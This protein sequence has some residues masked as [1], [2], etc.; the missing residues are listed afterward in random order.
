[1]K[2]WSKI[3][4][5]CVLALVMVLSLAACGTSSEPAPEAT[6]EVALD[7]EL[8]INIMSLNGP[9]GFG[10]AKMISDTAA[11]EAAL[12]YQFSV[13]ADPSN[14]T[15]ALVN[16]TCDIAALPTNAAST[17]YNKTEGAVQLLALNTRG[18]LYLVTDGSMEIT[19]FEDLKGQTIYVPAQNPTFI[20][21]FL[22]EKNGLKVGED[23]II[24]NT[25]AQS[26]DLRTALVS[27]EITMAVLPEPMV[28][29]A[30][31]ANDKLSVAMDLTEEWDKVFEPGS[32]VQ[33]CLV[34]R[35]E[36]A[37]A[38]PAE[39]AAF[40]SDYEASVAYIQSGDENV[41][42]VIEQSGVFAKGAVAA[43]AIP[44]CSL[45]YIVG[46]DMIAPMNTYLEIMFNA[47]PKSVG[48]ALPGEDFYYVAK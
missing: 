39:L 42:S 7:A 2:N 1:M 37:E 9:T 33:G 48:G 24:D 22:C 40:L 14:V 13:E 30:K 28:T 41:A 38:H 23:V 21:S 15:G 27:G 25:Y 17:L 11:G 44:N 16:G 19:S 32:L 35:K 5:S 43:K 8:P 29:I 10:L 45:C 12:N 34:V 46:E 6:P 36:F 47:Q 4:V 31:S 20:V 26:A 18:V 3:F